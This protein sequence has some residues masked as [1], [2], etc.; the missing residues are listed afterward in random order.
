MP[1]MKPTMKTTTVK[2]T[3]MKDQMMNPPIILSLAL[4]LDLA[5]ALD[6][7]A[8]TSGMTASHVTDVSRSHE[9]HSTLDR[10]RKVRAPKQYPDPR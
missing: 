4:D 6:P 7:L 9:N 10:N 8:V 5:L 2:T 3:L 1:L